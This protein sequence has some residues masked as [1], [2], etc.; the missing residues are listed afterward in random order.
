MSF[1][2]SRSAAL[3]VYRDG[4]RGGGFREIVWMD[5]FEGCHAGST[6]RQGLDWTGLLLWEQGALLG[7]LCVLLLTLIVVLVAAV[8]FCLLVS[9]D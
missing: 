4:A 3:R 5:A 1:I 2:R 6:Q 8:F 7:V 9:V